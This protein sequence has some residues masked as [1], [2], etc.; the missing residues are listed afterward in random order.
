MVRRVPG[1]LPCTAATYLD[2]LADAVGRAARGRAGRADERALQQTCVY[3][4][5]FVCV[6]GGGLKA[7]VFASV[8]H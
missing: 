3:V 7:S 4:R 6:W 8:K 2:G 1:P 5:L